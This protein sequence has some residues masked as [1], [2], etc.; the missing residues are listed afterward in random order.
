MN[1]FLGVAEPRSTPILVG[2]D[3]PIPVHSR[4]RAISP[5]GTAATVMANSTAKIGKNAYIKLAWLDCG[6]RCET[7]VVGGETA[8]GAGRSSPCVEFGISC[9][10]WGGC[11]GEGAE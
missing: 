10:D 7:E 9:F 5:F 11:G 2:K 3:R 1:P 4:K 6:R 8:G